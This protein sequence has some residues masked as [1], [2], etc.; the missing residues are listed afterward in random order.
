[1]MCT[2]AESPSSLSPVTSSGQTQ[3]DF[4]QWS[5]AGHLQTMY[6][7]AV[8]LKFTPLMSDIWWPRAVL[9]S[10]EVY[11]LSLPYVLLPLVT[12]VDQEQHEVRP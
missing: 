9:F 4:I 6:T 12:S 11:S 5:R 8:T 2:G 10:D 3:N 1:M 7:G